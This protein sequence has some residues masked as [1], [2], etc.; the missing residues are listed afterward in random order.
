M[1]QCARRVATN[2]VRGVACSVKRSI[3]VTV[4]KY[5]TRTNAVEHGETGIYMVTSFTHIL[6]FVERKH[7]L[8]P[9]STSCCFSLLPCLSLVQL[10]ATLQTPLHL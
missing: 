6:P 8:P 10:Y 9:A 1:L 7:Q 3:F 4:W 2:H 5:E